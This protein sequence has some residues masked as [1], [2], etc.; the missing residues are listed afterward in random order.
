MLEN[1][2]DVI[3]LQEPVTNQ[4][5]WIIEQTRHLYNH[6]GI[7]RDLLNYEHSGIFVRKDKFIVLEEGY[8]GINETKKVGLTGFGTKWPRYFSYLILSEVG[9][10]D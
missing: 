1:L 2:P 7:P 8:V 5:N 4:I 10:T 6:Y 3:G 9:R